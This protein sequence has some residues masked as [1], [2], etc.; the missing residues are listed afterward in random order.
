MNGIYTT[1]NACSL[2]GE[3]IRRREKRLRGRRHKDNMSLFINLLAH[4]I[5]RSSAGRAAPSG[6]LFEH[7]CKRHGTRPCGAY[8]VSVAIERLPGNLKDISKKQKL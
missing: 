6:K 5:T 2:L 4:Y 1:D 3:L 8:A 7:I